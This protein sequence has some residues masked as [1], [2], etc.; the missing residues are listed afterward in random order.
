MVDFDYLI[1]K[2]K[3]ADDDNFE[4]FLTPKTEFRTQALGDENLDEVKVDDVIQ[5]D[6]KG[7]FRV[8]QVHGG[9]KPLVMFL[10][11]TGKTK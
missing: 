10:I 7:Y 8:D 3:L 9:G 4:D 1:T 5:I 6:R 11:P 2:D